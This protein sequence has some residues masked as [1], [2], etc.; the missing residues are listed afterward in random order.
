M[1]G[2]RWLIVYEI[3]YPFTFTAVCCS[4]LLV[5]SRLMDFSKLTYSGRSSRWLL[6]GRVLVAVIVCGNLVGLCCNI[7]ASVF[8]SRAADIFQ[9]RASYVNTSD[10]NELQAKANDAMNS[11]TQLA[12]VHVGCETILLLLLVVAVS[13]VGAACVHRIR[14]AMR[15]VSET[16]KS[17]LLRSVAQPTAH[18]SSNAND[19]P[20]S[21]A[22]HLKLQIMGT[23]CVIFLSFCIRATHATMFTLASAFAS[24]Y[25]DCPRNIWKN[26]CSDC[27][28]IWYYILLWLLYTPD[29]HFCV[30][31][32]SLPLALLVALWGMTSGR[33]LEAMRSRGK[34]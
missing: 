17:T 3:T 28:N 18:R 31:L 4:K 29:V 8:F 20:L 5:L 24:N 32:V 34:T 25:N 27:Y 30:A 16:A 12:A 26:R 11:A 33:T 1:Q 14:T 15:A 9:S 2:L 6:A 7:A 19:Q 13:V 10:R 22:R 23:C 21:S